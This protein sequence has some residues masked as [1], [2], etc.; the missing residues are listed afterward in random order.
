MNQNPQN[1]WEL[2]VQA[3]YDLAE[4]HVHMDLAT[5]DHLLHP[6]Y[7]I[8][9]P[10]GRSENKTAVLDSYKQGVRKW[11]AATSTDLD[12]VV[13]GNLALVSGIWTASGQNGQGQ[14]N[15][16]ARFLSMWRKEDGRWQN[17]AYQSQ[18]FE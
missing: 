1:D 6:N 9:Q 14:F 2:V 10:D 3:E 16:S 11:E 5:I 18:E 17:I 7:T 15:Y 13:F 4:A 12:G 8:L